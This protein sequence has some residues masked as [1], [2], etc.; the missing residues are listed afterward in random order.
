VAR[1]YLALSRSGGGFS[2]LERHHVEQTVVLLCEAWAR[3]EDLEILERLR[4]CLIDKR[5][6][7][8]VAEFRDICAEILR[9]AAHVCHGVDLRSVAIDELWQDVQ[10][11]TSGPTI[12]LALKLANWNRSALTTRACGSTRRGDWSEERL[13][14]P[15]PLPQNAGD[16]PRSI[17]ALVCHTMR[18]YLTNDYQN[19]PIPSVRIFEDTHS[20]I[21]VPLA[22]GGDSNSGGTISVECDVL[23]AYDEDCPVLF[24]LPDGRTDLATCAE[25]KVFLDGEDPHKE[26]LNTADRTQWVEAAIRIAGRPIAKLALDFVGCPN[27]AVTLGEMRLVARFTRMLCVEAESIRARATGYRLRA[28]GLIASVLWH[29]FGN[30]IQSLRLASED[31]TLQ[32]IRSRLNRLGRVLDSYKNLL[33]R[34]AGGEP[35]TTVTL[36]EEFKLIDEGFSALSHGDFFERILWLPEKAECGADRVAGDHRPLA[37]IVLLLLTN[38]LN[39]ILAERKK[40]PSHTAKISL[41]LYREAPEAPLRRIEIED[42]GGGVDPG[43]VSS[44]RESLAKPSTAYTNGNQNGLVLAALLAQEN[45]WTLRLQ[46]AGPPTVFEISLRI[47]E[48]EEDS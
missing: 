41:R 1:G 33:R 28:L 27:H 32:D 21:T 11:A 18:A 2:D 22:A 29:Q 7:L 10:P 42:S 24:V 39:A 43:K 3:S 20:H 45:G 5:C 25:F 48:P 36:A 44:I 35:P 37:H 34:K 23:G 16:Q 40:A 4:H 30:A 19:V 15:Y 38:S 8:H 6:L 26:E 47:A 12:R 46:Q 14:M 9:Q 13:R 31:K 17:A